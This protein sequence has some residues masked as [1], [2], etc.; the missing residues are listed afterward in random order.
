MAN[1]PT[2]FRASFADSCYFLGKTLSLTGENEEAVQPL[3]RSIEHRTT[4]A[5]IDPDTYDRRLAYS[6]HDLAVCYSRLKKYQDALEPIE[7][8]IELR[9]KQAKQ[10]TGYSLD[11]AES[12]DKKGFCL[13]KLGQYGKAAESWKR[14]VEIL[15]S[16]EKIGSGSHDKMLARYLTKLRVVLGEQGRYDEAAEVTERAIHVLEARIPAKS[17]E[18]FHIL[19]LADSLN[20]LACY[21]VNLGKDAEALEK[22]SRCLDLQRDLMKIR[23]DLLCEETCC[24]YGNALE[25]YSYILEKMG[26]KREALDAALEAI[27]LLEKNKEKAA[28]ICPRAFG[29]LLKRVIRLISFFEN[30]VT[31]SYVSWECPG[32]LG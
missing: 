24:R 26:R 13:E 6:Y 21:L 18:Q 19:S 20:G 11:L 2:R 7:F 14:A 23:S 10:K 25:M 31:P 15:S 4:L 16:L 22:I 32:T 12:L 3:K 17:N 5:L 29:L 27:L 30:D 28:S 8:A 1:D 9:M